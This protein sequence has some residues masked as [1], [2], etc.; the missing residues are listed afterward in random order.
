V[1]GLA[2]VSF[3]VASLIEQLFSAPVVFHWRAEDAVIEAVSIAPDGRTV[4]FWCE[5]LHGAEAKC[6]A[7]RA[8]E[9]AAPIFRGGALDAADRLLQRPSTGVRHFSMKG[10]RVGWKNGVP[11]F[12][13]ACHT[14]AIT[15]VCEQVL[16]AEPR[17]VGSAT[18]PLDSRP[19]IVGETVI[20]NDVEMS[21]TVF[22]APDLRIDV[23][24]AGEFAAYAAAPAAA[25]DVLL[26]YTGAGRPA[27]LRAALLGADLHVKQDAV[28]VRGIP[29]PTSIEAAATAD[30]T[31]VIWSGGGVFAAIKGRVVKLSDTGERPVIATDGTRVL[32][33]WLERDR[34]M[35]VELSRG[36]L[37]RS[38]LALDASV[39]APFLALDWSPS[40]GFVAHWRS[41]STRPDE[42]V[43]A[44]RPVP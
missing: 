41:R 43:V 16:G 42:I 34:V 21:Q 11:L 38:L 36:D 20:W 10:G 24:C 8:D 28:L 13:V 35:T 33:A 3:I 30:R 22:R 29:A 14:G 39:D 25:G 19:T 9:A 5:G 6:F 23:C 1:H 27:D 40:A 37:P 44:A 32:A 7:Q 15:G 17:V 18:S 2:L 4:A 12:L 31:V 26:V